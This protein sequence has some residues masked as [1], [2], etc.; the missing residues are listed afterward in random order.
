MG[1]VYLARQIALDREVALKVLKGMGEQ[2]VARFLGE[3]KLLA[4]LP[5]P[6]ILRVID[7]G[8][9]GSLPYLVLERVVGETLQSLLDREPLYSLGFDPY[10]ATPSI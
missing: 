2:E 8:F 7:A 1:T 4:S 9:D 10:T 6:R 3:G 5:H